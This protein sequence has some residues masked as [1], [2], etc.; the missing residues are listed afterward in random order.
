VRIPADSSIILLFRNNKNNKKIAKNQQA[1][2]ALPVKPEPEGERAGGAARKG[3][4]I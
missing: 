3:I 2:L 1:I 4:S